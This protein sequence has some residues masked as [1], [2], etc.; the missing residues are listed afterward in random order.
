[1]RRTQDAAQ[2]RGVES[3]YRAQRTLERSRSGP[4]RFYVV[5]GRVT[6]RI[7]WNPRREEYGARGVVLANGCCKKG[8]PCVSSN[9]SDVMPTSPG[10]IALRMSMRLLLRR[11]AEL[12]R[13]RPHAVLRRDGE[14]VEEKEASEPVCER[15]QA[16]DV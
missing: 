9:K 14:E 6:N 7:A 10:S 12:G 4:Y 1:M 13:E 2:P 8:V 5:T 3:Y 16:P 15:N 11:N